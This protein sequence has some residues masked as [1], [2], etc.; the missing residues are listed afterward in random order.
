[1]VDEVHDQKRAKIGEWLSSGYLSTRH[2]ELRRTR[3][4]DSGQWFL[5]SE[6]F[7]GWANGTRPSC[8]VCTGIR[9][10]IHV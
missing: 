1:V 9:M 8:L 5:N 10:T 3:A 2:E 4:K 7:L 6:E